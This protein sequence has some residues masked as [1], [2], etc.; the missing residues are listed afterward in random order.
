MS[1]A[2]VLK[3]AVEATPTRELP[4][5][6]VQI[7]GQVILKVMQHCSQSATLAT[8]QLLGLDVGQTLEVTDCFAFPVSFDVGPERGARARIRRS[9]ET[10]RRRRRP[11]ARPPAR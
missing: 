10:R 1:A 7:D 6:S 2:D 9:D 3:R 8:G 5:K 4:L 11:N